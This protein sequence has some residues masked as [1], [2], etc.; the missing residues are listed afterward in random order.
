[1]KTFCG[2]VCTGKKVGFSFDGT[3]QKNFLDLTVP[4]SKSASKLQRNSFG[5][6]KNSL[7]PKVIVKNLVEQKREAFIGCAPVK[8]HPVASCAQKLKHLMPPQGNVKVKSA[9]DGASHAKQTSIASF[10][11]KSS[12]LRRTRNVKSHSNKNRG[13]SVTQVLKARQKQGSAK[14][15][16]Y[17]RNDT[18]KIPNK[19]V[20]QALKAGQNQDGVKLVLRMRSEKPKVDK[21]ATKKKKQVRHRWLDSEI[22]ALREGLNKHGQIKNVKGQKGVWATIRDDPTLGLSHK[23]NAQIKDKAR[24]L[25]KQNKVA[26]P[27]EK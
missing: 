16:I 22:K 19:C 11:S 26:T 18:P 4:D 23:S 1:M 6:R 7:L 27:N 24:H 21:D 12:Q 3:P 25:L 2:N 14:I 17:E 9:K 13:K 10:I 20:T 8:A 15:N 5:G